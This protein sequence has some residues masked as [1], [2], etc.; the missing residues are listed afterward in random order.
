MIIHDLLNGTELS[1]KRLGLPTA[2]AASKL[3]TGGGAPSKSMSHYAYALA[4]DI[5]NGKTTNRFKGTPD[6]EDG[7]K[8]E[9]V[10]RSWYSFFTGNT[11]TPVGFCT[12]DDGLYGCTPDNLIYDNGLAQYKVRIKAHLTYMD[13][14]E[15]AGFSISDKPQLQFELLVTGRE[16]TDLV[17]Y[18]PKLESFICRHYRDEPYIQTLKSQIEKCIEKRDDY[19]KTNKYAAKAIN[20]KY[21]SV[22]A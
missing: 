15:R 13:K 3:I 11:L 5:A 17:N 2:S 14:I 4:M 20:A 19:L 12:D 18:H 22:A 1:P 10:A 16:W 21:R 9:P 6:T 8:Y 7:H